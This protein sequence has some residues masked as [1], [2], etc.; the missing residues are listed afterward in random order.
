MKIRRY[1]II[2]QMIFWCVT[3]PAQS[4]T[5]IPLHE[6]RGHYL[7]D[8]SYLATHP[9]N[10][11]KQT[12]EFIFDTGANHTAMTSRIALSVGYNPE[13]APETIAHALTQPF[14]SDV[15]VI[16]DFDF[17]TGPNRIEALVVNVDESLGVR[18]SGILGLDNFTSGTLEINFIDQHLI[19]NA[20]V[21]VRS[22][23]GVD[24]EFGLLM[25]YGESRRINQ[26]IHI[27]LDSGSNVT[28]ANEAYA[29]FTADTTMGARTAV[30]DV[31]ASR[32]QRIRSSTFFGQT[33]IGNLCI[34][35]AE[36]HVADLY[37]F[38]YY[39]L[40]DTPALI[41]GMDILKNSIVRIDFDTGNVSIDGF[42]QFRC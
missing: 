2:M 16:E 30:R 28:I 22:D 15:H 35:R 42:R 38:D 4:Q 40:H 6:D 25:G 9:A 32:I 14:V 39:G 29:R 41:L 21:N 37:V 31:S 18:A 7:I 26:P 27:I 1:L 3:A 10:P 17:G 13:D 20:D 36:I 8:V 34:P 12:A 33:S 5:Y 19:V 24:P 11:E 23:L